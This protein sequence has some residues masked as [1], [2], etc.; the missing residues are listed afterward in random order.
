M[1]IDLGANRAPTEM[2]LMSEGYRW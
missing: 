1:L 2:R